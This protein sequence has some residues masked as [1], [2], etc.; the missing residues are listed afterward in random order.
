MAN[1]YD[2]ISSTTLSSTATSVTF[3][4]IPNTYTDLILR[5]SARSTFTSNA[6]PN[7]FYFRLNGDATALYSSINVLQQDASIFS[8]RTSGAGS[9]WFDSF[10]INSNLSTTNTFSNAEF[11][12]PSYTVSQNKPISNF[13]IADNNATTA[14]IVG[15]TAGLYR[16]T[17]A[18]NSVTFTLAGPAGSFMAD[19]SF[20]LYGIKNS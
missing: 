4:S 11:Y 2:L 18:I 19:S 16:S 7:S 10:S 14:G 6:Y 12:I 8:L 15:A 13:G 20:Y 3:S 17:S 5:A 1:T 9:T